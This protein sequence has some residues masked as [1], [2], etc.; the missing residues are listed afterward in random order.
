[1][2][3]IKNRESLV[4]WSEKT[5]KSVIE[6]LKTNSETG[7]TEAQA[8]E[9]LLAYGLNTL[10]EA[11]RASWL[12]VF[13]RQFQSPLIYILLFAAAIIF[14]VGDDPLEALVV[15]GV[16][17]FN[18]MIGM[19]QEGRA[20]SILQGLKR[21]VKTSSV[22]FRGGQKIFI[23]S[24][25]LVVGD[26]IVLQEGERVPADAR[27][28]EANVLCIDEAVLTGESA[29]VEKEVDPLA[30]GLSVQDQRNMVFKG[31]YVLSGSGKAVVTATGVATQIGQLHFMAEAVETDMPL[32][33]EMRRL[34]VW[35]LWF[36]FSICIFLF[37][38]GLAWGKPIAELLTTLTALFICVIPE[39]LP[40]V[41]TLVLVSG[42]YTLARKNVLVKRMQA[43]EALGR[44]DVIIIDKTGTLT[45]NEM[46]IS[47]V[48]VG[49]KLLTVTGVGYFAQGNVLDAGNP[50]SLDDNQELKMLARAGALLNRSELNFVPDT[51]LFD[52]KGN[53][54][55]IAMSVF[56]KKVGVTQEGLAS[57][58]KNIYEIPFDAQLQYHALFCERHGRGI[59]FISGSPEKLIQNSNGVTD[60][61]KQNLGVMLQEGL[62]IIALATKSFDIATV[63]HEVNGNGRREWAEKLVAS[64]L[65]LLG[66]F[67]IQDSIRPEVAG[68]IA[69]AR[70]AG[71]RI[72]MAT[73]DHKRTALFVGQQVG[74]FQE[75][76]GILDGVEL[77]KL[78]R[79]EL[80]RALRSVTIFAR[81]TP[82]QKMSLVLALQK[83]GNIVAMTGDGVND[84]PSIMAADLGIAMGR[85]GTE[86]TKQAADL[87]LLDDSLVSIVNAVEYGRH[88]FYTLRRV[89][90]YFFSTNAG[91]VLIVLFAL[92]LGMPLPLTA[93]QILWLNLITDGFLD[94]ALSTEKKEEGLLR[95]EAHT[96][97]LHVV[98]WGTALKMLYVA[99]PMAFFSLF[100]FCRT[101]Y[102]DLRHART[103]ALLTMAAFQ[104][105]N[106]LNCRSETK[107]I[108]QLGLFSNRW[109]LLAM[110]VV[111]GLQ[112]FVLYNPFMQRLFKTVPISLSEWSWVILSASSIVVMEEARKWIVRRRKRRG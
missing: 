82:R 105:F 103:M 101:C 95:H 1:M 92:M 56:A 18:A 45:R 9:R 33:R 84:I 106:A 66:M 5:I 52:I 20:R 107:S 31:T 68:I 109:L 77:E 10:P 70:S 22:V 75:G 62:R 54:T 60:N 90:L 80:E 73:G 23:S 29:P 98:D 76:D 30:P 19:L 26:I 64:D 12:L 97:S 34:S 48:A 42:V 17:F 81:V 25:Q 58:Y 55:E 74:L 46:V 88:I 14:F 102:T 49:E 83:Q 28:I 39:G 78:S 89:V 41:L 85:I 111:L 13:L 79:V 7:L 104:W 53:P 43:V 94:T 71:I 69:Q 100:L 44:A 108:F 2:L 87:V 57:E 110:S 72:I 16:L 59:V 11:S 21:F 65:T 51:N 47:K 36:I 32:K 8:R 112:V 40:V 6:E 93:V 61:L 86:A 4:N 24:E 15:C 91:E 50:V 63:P 27:I 67:G 99:V 38:I 35:I 96:G 3:A 37:G